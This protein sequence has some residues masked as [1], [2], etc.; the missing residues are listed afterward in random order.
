M[1]TVDF[2]L[3]SV[4]SVQGTPLKISVN[5][6]F[7]VDVNTLPKPVDVNVQNLDLVDA[8]KRIAGTNPLAFD[9]CQQGVG[10]TYFVR[11]STGN[12]VAVFK[13]SDEEPG[14]P[15]NPKKVLSSPILPPGGG[16]KR[17][18]VAYLF[19]RGFAGVPQT[20]LLEDMK[21][22]Q[23]PGVS[24]T[25]SLQQ[26]V[27]HQF[28]SAD[29]GT[30]LFY[31][32]DVHKIGVLDLRLLNLDRNG[33]NLLAVKESNLFKLVP[34][35]HSYILPEKIQNPFFEWLHWKQPK[36]PFSP[37]T[38]RY[39]SEIDVEADTRL[40]RSFSFS[41]QS[42]RT[43]QIMATLLK[44]AALS[45]LSLFRIAS[46]VSV[47]DDSETSELEKIVSEA[48]VLSNGNRDTF[49]HFFHPLV[50]ELVCKHCK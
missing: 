10:G 9:L 15:G 1:F 37:E 12:R 24:K 17:E 39:I 35:D 2:E 11:D 32:D 49:F 36:E 25:G 50:D 22:S 28:V 16:T 45:G 42:I 21:H 44:R 34:I 47:N 30:S 38:L 8:V 13:P 31:V 6:V 43:M 19:D 40:L 14:A 26:Y 41:E 27:P 5:I 3:F 18:V 29:L 46:L 23:W 33:E 7:D 20:Y 48:D 4:L